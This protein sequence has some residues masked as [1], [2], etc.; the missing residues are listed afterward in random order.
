MNDIF[1]LIGAKIL[2]IKMDKFT[3]ERGVLKMVSDRRIFI[4]NLILVEFNILFL[5][6]CVG[7]SNNPI[8]S[9]VIIMEFMIIRALRNSLHY[10]KLYMC[11]FMTFAIL[12]SLFLVLKINFVL[13]I[14]ATFLSAIGLS[15]EGDSNKSSIT[16]VMGKVITE[17][18]MYKPKSETKYKV[19]DNHIHR[20]PNSKEVIE[21]GER[22]RLCGDEGTYN[23]YRAR[24]IDR[25]ENDE[26][27]SIEEIGQ[28]TGI[29]PR[30][31]I[32]KLDN[33]LLSFKV[34]CNL[35]EK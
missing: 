30:R 20:N 28:M 18:F 25:G 12:M 32:E 22:L 7:F 21:F 34:F 10:D 8:H 16:D 27:P 1:V 2:D 5:I 35:S 19:M 26:Y 6:S 13:A 23:V 29:K 4:R 3:K 17:G 11:T 9:F 33:I 14:V 24:F 15:E 31:V